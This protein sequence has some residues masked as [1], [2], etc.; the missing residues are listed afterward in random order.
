[1]AIASW[2]LHTTMTTTMDTKMEVKMKISEI[3]D[4]KMMI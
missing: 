2:S 1:M 3:G 4:S